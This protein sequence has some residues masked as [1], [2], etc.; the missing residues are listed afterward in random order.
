MKT[1][2]L[3]AKFLAL[4]LVIIALA[5][6]QAPAPQEGASEEAASASD[7]VMTDVGTP[8]N[9]TLIFQT[10]DRQTSNP[11]QMNPMLAYSVWRGFRELGFGYLWETDTGTGESYGE[12]AAGPAEALND[13][14]T[15]FRINLKE[16]IY[17]SDG[18]EFTADDIIYSLDTYFACQDVATRVGGIVNYVKEDSWEKIDNYTLELETNNPAYDI[19]QNLGVRT[20]GSNLVPLPKH[21]FETYENPCEDKNTYP[22]T[23]GPYTVK[24][25]DETG[26][27]QLWELRED[28]ERSAWADLDQDGYMP[29]YV[30]YKDF[31]PEETRCA[32]LCPERL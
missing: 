29:Q 6:C 2:H 26:F 11:D 14:H 27:W 7:G 8:R 32:L 1:V 17:W 24:E 9:E 25:F 15:K 4:T 10:F 20:W 31:G 23:L 5:A 22:V 16:G 19:Q 21:V 13:E 18:V 12:L 3:L 28:W 30:L